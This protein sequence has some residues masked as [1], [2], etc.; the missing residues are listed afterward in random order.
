M[1]TRKVREWRGEKK[2]KKENGDLRGSTENHIKTL[3]MEVG[4]REKCPLNSI[5][6]VQL[7][8]RPEQNLNGT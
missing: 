1:K 2:K 6:K 4:E 5:K 8:E 7:T 3:N